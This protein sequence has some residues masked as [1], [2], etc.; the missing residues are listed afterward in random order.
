MRTG[1]ITLGGKPYPVAGLSV[2]QSL[3]LDMKMAAKGSDPVDGRMRRVATALQNAGAFLPDPKNPSGQ[4]K[5]SD[6]SLDDVVNALDAGDFI[7]DMGEWYAAELAV[8]A[9]NGKPQSDTAKGPVAVED[10]PKGEEP[11][12]A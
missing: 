1:E 2:R 11:A 10:L 8:I 5:T 3:D 4:F 12:T 9:L 6:V 7:T